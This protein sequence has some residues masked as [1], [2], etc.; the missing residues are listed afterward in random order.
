MEAPGEKAD[1]CVIDPGQPK[2]LTN[3]NPPKSP[4][5]SAPPIRLFRFNRRAAQFLFSI[6]NE[7]FGHDFWEVSVFPKRSY[8]RFFLFFLFLFF[9]RSF[10]YSSFYTSVFYIFLRITNLSKWSDS[11]N[12]VF[13]KFVKPLEKIF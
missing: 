1:Y 12:T 7:V 9:D 4:H 13:Q 5:S 10:R 8:E 6:G 2:N 11:K 3:Q